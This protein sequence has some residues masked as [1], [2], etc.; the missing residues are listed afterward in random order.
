MGFFHAKHEEFPIRG[1]KKLPIRGKR[2]KRLKFL[3]QFEVGH[4]YTFTQYFAADLPEDLPEHLLVED[5]ND[6]HHRHSHN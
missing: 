6:E 2:A 5:H 1:R 3:K 4:L